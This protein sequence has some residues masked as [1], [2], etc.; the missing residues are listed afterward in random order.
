MWDPCSPSA[1]LAFPDA[2]PEPKSKLTSFYG[3]IYPKGTG[4]PETLEISEQ[5]AGPGQIPAYPSAAS[6]TPRKSWDTG[7]TGRCILEARLLLGSHVS[8]TV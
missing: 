8:P 5:K 6:V 4:G 7:P 1:P 2:P 3:Q